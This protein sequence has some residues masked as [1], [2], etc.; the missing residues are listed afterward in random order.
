[1]DGMFVPNI[2]F[3][4]PVMEAVASVCTKPLDVHY[5]IEQPE[6]IPT[7]ILVDTELILRESTFP[8]MTGSIAASSP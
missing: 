7:P 5:M 2:S 3:G 6:L 1:M 8:G 4:F